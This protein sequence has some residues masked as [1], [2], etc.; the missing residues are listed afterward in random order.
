MGSKP[1]FATEETAEQER[2][3]LPTRI[4]VADLNGDA[5]KD[6]V[7][8]KNPPESSRAFQNLKKYP[9]GKIHALTWNGLGLVS[10]W[11]GDQIEGMVAD[12]QLRMHKNGKS[13]L[14]VGLVLNTDWVDRS[15]KAESVILTYPLNINYTKK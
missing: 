3:Y 11:E 12:Y 7:V 15:S 4:V 6:I 2:V 9:T 5:N 8:N 14:Y 13:K 10:I 1:G